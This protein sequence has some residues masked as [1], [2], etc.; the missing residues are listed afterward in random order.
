MSWLCSASRSRGSSSGNGGEGGG[1]AESGRFMD[2]DPVVSSLV[3]NLLWTEGQLDIMF[4]PGR[5]V[6]RE[7]GGL[8]M[9]RLS[10]E[11]GSG[12]LSS[13]GW[14]LRTRTTLWESSGCESLGMEI[15]CLGVCGSLSCCPIRPW[16]RRSENSSSF[17]TGGVS[18]RVAD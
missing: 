10:L 9:R 6:R 16:H 12:G 8:F 15:H 1:G 17:E 3:W 14:R 13:L 7:F 2:C 5:S 4:D 11:L 18:S